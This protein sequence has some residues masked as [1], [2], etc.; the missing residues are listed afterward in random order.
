MNVD[1]LDSIENVTKLLRR[2]W[3]IIGKY[4][5]FTNF[6]VFSASVMHLFKREFCYD[7]DSDVVS[8]SNETLSKMLFDISPAKKE[9]KR[10]AREQLNKYNHDKSLI[11]SEVLSVQEWESNGVSK[12]LEQVAILPVNDKMTK[13][14]E[15]Y[16]ATSGLNFI[17]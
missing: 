3:G 1:D 10:K 7:D 17:Q 5:E 9:A 6:Y 16:L 14:I 12:L 11:P 8:L 13:K 4:T 15:K 2:T